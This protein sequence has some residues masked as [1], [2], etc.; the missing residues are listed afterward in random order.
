[1]PIFCGVSYLL[2][3]SPNLY[4]VSVG[5]YVGYSEERAQCYLRSIHAVFVFAFSVAIGETM[6]AHPPLAALYFLLCIYCRTVLCTGLPSLHYD[7]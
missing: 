4:D 5:R 2:P 7:V 6:N 1:M 3:D